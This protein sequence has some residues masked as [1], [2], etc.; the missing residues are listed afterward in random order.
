MHHSSSVEDRGHLGGVSSSVIDPGIKLRVPSCHLFKKYIFYFVLV[1]V[2]VC[3]WG[4]YLCCVAGV[5]LFACVCGTRV[6]AYKGQHSG[7]DSVLCDIKLLT[8]HCRASLAR[9]FTW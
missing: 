2:C 6:G 5:C 1:H 9:A 3:V 7:L 8:S 4:M